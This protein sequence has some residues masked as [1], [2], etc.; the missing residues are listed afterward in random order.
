[1]LH[2]QYYPVEEGL[3]GNFGIQ[4]MDPV[5]PDTVPVLMERAVDVGRSQAAVGLNSVL[6][7]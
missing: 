2:D 5:F 6:I 1:M 4:N 7:S 3:E